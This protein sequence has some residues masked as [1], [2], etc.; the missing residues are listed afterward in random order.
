MLDLRKT[1]IE[2]NGFKLRCTKCKNDPF[3][4][5]KAPCGVMFSLKCCQS[6][7]KLL[8]RSVLDW[9][10]LTLLKG[11]GVESCLQLNELME[12]PVGRMLNKRLIPV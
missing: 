2:I 8:N 12:G 10:A 5:F 9:R 7:E 11:G 1:C 4:V 3:A 6:V